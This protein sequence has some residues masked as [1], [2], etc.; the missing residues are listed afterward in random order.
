MIQSP[1]LS[2]QLLEE[3]HFPHLL[4]M[5]AEPDSN[6]YIR[7]LRN[8]T[9]EEYQAFF[10]FKIE[11]NRAKLGF[12]WAVFDEAGDL[13][14]SANFNHFPPFNIEHV[15]VHLSR[16]VW[17]KGYGTEIVKALLDYAQAEGRKEVHA[18]V[19]E[20]HKA[21][22]RMLEKAGMQYL[23]QKENQGDSL[24]IYQKTWS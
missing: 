20:E 4:K 23:R 13:I 24:L 2:Y 21:S 5:Y 22:I 11:Q 7:P 1:R 19:E 14:G 12:F 6:K 18:L 8:K 15:G 17:G 9:L 10:E 3:A 16:Q